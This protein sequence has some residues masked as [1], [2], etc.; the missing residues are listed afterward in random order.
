MQSRVGRP[1]TSWDVT[2]QNICDC[3]DC[4][5]SSR[6]R[7]NQAERR[8]RRP[9]P[10]PFR[11]APSAA[12]PR[13][14]A[15]A[16]RAAAAPPDPAAKPLP[17]PPLPTPPG[18]PATG[19][20]RPVPRQRPRARLFQRA[21]LGGGCAPPAVALP[22]RRPPW[23]GAWRSAACG[24]PRRGRPSYPLPLSSGGCSPPLCRATADPRGDVPVGGGAPR[25]SVGGTGSPC[26]LEPRSLW[27]RIGGGGRLEWGWR[28]GGA[29]TG[30]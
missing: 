23:A 12:R 17:R 10:R 29:L 22:P 21:P 18:P 24:V 6:G 4:M 19:P 1:M 27:R 28:G 3:L 11:R 20:A 9:S 26:R 25:R 30:A 13:H 15:R 16:P 8:R 5:P 2:D 14:S 7:R